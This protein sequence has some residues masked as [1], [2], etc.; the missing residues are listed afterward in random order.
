MGP[1]DSAANQSLAGSSPEISGLPVSSGIPAAP[2]HPQPADGPTSFVGPQSLQVG[3]ALAAVT[4]PPSTSHTFTLSPGLPGA[5][6]IAAVALGHPLSHS[7]KMQTIDAQLV[8]TPG[9]QKTISDEDDELRDLMP[10][11]DSSDNEDDEL[12]DLMPHSGSNE[13]DE[14]QAPLPNKG[15]R[16]PVRQESNPSNDNDEVQDLLPGNSADKLQRAGVLEEQ[17]AS[18]DD[19]LLGLPY[20]DSEQ[21][22]AARS[23]AIQNQ[24]GGIQ[25]VSN[26]SNPKDALFFLMRTSSSQS[27]SS[28]ER[29]ERAEALQVLLTSCKTTVAY[30]MDSR[31]TP[32]EAAFSE[33]HLESD[34][35]LLRGR[36]RVE[37]QDVDIIFHSGIS[38]ERIQ[39]LKQDPRFAGCIFIGI[40]KEEKAFLKPLFLKIIEANRK[41]NA[42]EEKKEEAY[43][44]SLHVGPIRREDL[45]KGLKSGRAIGASTILDRGETETNQRELKEEEKRAEMEHIVQEHQQEAIE[46]QNAA[47]EQ[48]RVKNINKREDQRKF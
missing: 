35:M 48:E 43:T 47:W 16:L 15:D 44:G 9:G 14:L 12:R 37:D 2:S 25:R 18:S 31:G 3:N 30:K 7:L 1:A 33:E 24:V 21:G 32:T 28:A 23:G 6:K 34:E 17:E 10:H 45:A 42:P 29:A 36:S 46:K 41:A 13:D 22:G 11:S 27:M 40:S 4:Q 5:D 19:G 38:E 39:K 8:I 20:G 26:I